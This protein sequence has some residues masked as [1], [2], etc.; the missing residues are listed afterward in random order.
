MKKI[1]AAAL[2]F[3]LPSLA[4]AQIVGALPFQLQ[5]GTTADATQVMADFNKILNDTNTNAAKNG[6]NS[7][8]TALT[9]LITPITPAAGGSTVYFASTSGG[10]ANAQTVASPTPT[11]FTLAVGKRVTFI[12]GFT[13]T[14]AMTL[15]VNSTGATNV[16]RYTPSG[17]VALTGGEVIAN[18]YVEVV[19]DGTQYQLYT[20]AALPGY[21]PATSLASA[22]TTDLGTI[23]SHNV[24]ITG[25][26]TIT[27]FGSSAVTTYPLYKLKFSGILT[28]TYNG[29]SLILPGGV[30][31]TTAANDT[32]EAL[33]LGSGNWQVTAYN[34]AS[35]QPLGFSANFLQGYI[36][37]CTLSTAGPSTTMS[38]A[39]CEATD[40]TN[41]QVMI[42]AASSKTT[43]SWAVGA[44]TG[45]LDT[46]SIVNSTWYHFFEMIRPD[47][48]VVDY[49]FS[50]TVSACTTVSGGGN[51]PNAY[52]LFRRIGS[53]KTNGSGQWTLFTQ[54][55][56]KFIWAAA[57]Q[58]VNGIASTAAR[59]N[60]TLTVPTG[61]TVT[62]LF[63]GGLT[64][65]AA[66][67]TYTQF[68]SLIET[69][70]GVGINNADIGVGS[71]G[72]F[73][74][75]GA[76][77]FERLTDTSARIGVRSSI[78]SGTAAVYV[79]TYGW[80]DNRGKQ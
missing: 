42:G 38:I 60:T 56:D 14:G 66:A 71:D 65:T 68:S 52:T 43:A 40:S 34:R 45:G 59:V 29:T 44:A 27:S 73:V 12:A 46:G 72:T 39:A 35:G 62:A 80:I 76:G 7:D 1:L 10:S 26:T 41:A 31:I 69:D 53:G 25:T 64:Q 19:Y 8:I 5:N 13:N 30:S 77:S 11:G 4:Q 75:S 55:G 61:V 33:Y 36:N 6:V 50:T 79:S 23:P 28:L 20:N 51:V 3:L 22:T 24:T 70:A 2:L 58:D 78:G 57:V 74:G 47:T 63:R 49:C 54:V 17:P 37:G 21:G 67:T 32:A 18:N 9:A 16:Y 15:N 48:G